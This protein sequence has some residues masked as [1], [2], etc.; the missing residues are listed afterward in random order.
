MD[1]L[2]AIL[3]VPA[4]AVL[5][6]VVMGGTEGAMAGFVVGLLAAL[7]LI[8]AGDSRKDRLDELEREVEELR[9][10]RDEDG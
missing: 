5:Y 6:G 10:T 2:T 1:Q 7:L 8:F 4:V 9:R 3:L